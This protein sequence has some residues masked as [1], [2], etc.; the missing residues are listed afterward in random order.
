M[1]TAAFAASL[2]S[3]SVADRL[4][5]A[6][7]F[8]GVVVLSIGWLSCMGDHVDVI[9]DNTPERIEHDHET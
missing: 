4:L 1:N 6:L 8:V 9:L 7:L 2:R 3:C 5:T